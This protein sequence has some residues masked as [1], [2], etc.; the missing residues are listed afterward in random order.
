MLQELPRSDEAG[1]TKV[2]KEGLSVVGYRDELAWRGVGIGYKTNEWLVMRRKAVG[3][4]MVADAEEGGQHGVLGGKCSSQ[5]GGVTGIIHEKLRKRS[6][7]SLRQ[8]ALS[9][10]ALS[11]WM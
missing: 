6:N 10:L 9:D 3:R 8:L 11:A 1:W 7:F 5:P 4:A 2:E